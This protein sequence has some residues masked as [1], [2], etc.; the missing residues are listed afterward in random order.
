[1]KTQQ[2]PLKWRSRKK[3]RKKARWTRLSSRRKKSTKMKK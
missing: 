2:A 1:M 3:K